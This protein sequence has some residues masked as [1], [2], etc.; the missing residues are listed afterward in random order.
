MWVEVKARFLAGDEDEKLAELLGTKP[1]NEVDYLCFD[2]AALV[3]FNPSD[4][5]GCTAI[6]L[7]NGS[8]HTIELPYEN[9]KTLLNLR[10]LKA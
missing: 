3:S 1:G 4:E 10:I 6:R 2:T 8:T 9:L 5:P 7:R